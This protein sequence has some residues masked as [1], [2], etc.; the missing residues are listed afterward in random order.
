[1]KSSAANPA[2]VTIRPLQHEET[3]IERHRRDDAGSRQVRSQQGSSGRIS[4]HLSH[5]TQL[6]N[7][8]RYQSKPSVREKETFLNCS[9]EN[10]SRQAQGLYDVSNPGEARDEQMPQPIAPAFSISLS[11]PARR[12]DN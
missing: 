6:P 10:V 1:M 7:R 3:T 2:M 4:H 11:D 9:R 12:S 8:L 5:E